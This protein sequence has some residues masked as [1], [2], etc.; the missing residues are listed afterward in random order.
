ME[1]HTM[2]NIVLNETFI[3][4]FKLDAKHDTSSQKTR[5]KLIDY[6]IDAGI[7]F[8]KET[9]SKEQLTQIKELIPLRFPAR[10]QYLLKIGADKADGEIVATHSGMRY[11]K[12][13]APCDYRFWN[14]EIGNVMRGLARGVERRKQK[15]ARVAS[16]G[17]TTRSL[18]ERLDQEQNKLYNALVSANV[19]NLPEN[20]DLE[21][22]F[23]GFQM[24][25]KALKFNLVKKD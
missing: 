2:S 15:E 24:I 8:T 25:A 10:A 7:D 5:G 4:L 3:N 16:G 13:G 1:G 20:I 22:A 11:T 23:E 14:N 6:C 12:Q 21:K 18:M 9:L 17:N 19:D